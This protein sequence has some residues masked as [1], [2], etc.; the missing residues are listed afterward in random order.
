MFSK[1]SR[2]FP[3]RELTHRAPDGREIIYKERRMIPPTPSSRDVTL[4]QS[5]RLDLL[6]QRI[7]KDPLKFW[8]LCDANEELNPFELESRSGRSVKVPST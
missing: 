4:P 1:T 6:A 8:R 2:Y 7:L 3:L 5:G